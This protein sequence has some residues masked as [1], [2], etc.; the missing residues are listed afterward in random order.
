M[1]GP[2]VVQVVVPGDNEPAVAMR[3]RFG[4]TEL[5]EIASGLQWTKAAM[6]CGRRRRTR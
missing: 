5:D 6:F 4:F 1:K 2:T 3:K